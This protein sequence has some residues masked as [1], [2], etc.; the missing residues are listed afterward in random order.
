MHLAT[1]DHYCDI[2]TTKQYTAWL[3]V[4]YEAANQCLCILYS[5][6]Y[7]VVDRVARTAP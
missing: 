7:F 6:Q 1:C 2:Y 5:Y 3:H 4:E